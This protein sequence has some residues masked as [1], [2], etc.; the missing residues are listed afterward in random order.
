MI[1]LGLE[2]PVPYNGM[3][4]FDPT[5]AN[6]VLNAQNNYIQAMKEDY[7]RGREDLKEFNKN[8][9]DFFSPIQKD[10]EWYDQNVTGATRDFI[11]GLYERGIDP[12]RSPEARAMISR[13]VNNM[14]TGKINQL[15]QSAA[16]ANEYLKNMGKLMAEDRY[17]PDA[18]KSF[19]RDLSTW[20][21]LGG[22]GLWNTPSPVENRT[23]D[24]II[25]PIIK[26]LDYTYDEARTKQAN[27]GNDYYTVTEDRIRATIADAMEDLTRNGTMPGYYYNK[28]LQAVGG[29]KDKAI[30]LYTDW[31]TNRGKDHLKEKFTPNEFAILKKKHEYDVALENLKDKHIRDRSGGDGPGNKTNGPAYDFATD[32]YDN[33]LNNI[34]GY[35]AGHMYELGPGG[36]FVSAEQYFQGSDKLVKYQNVFGKDVAKETKDVSR[37]KRMYLDRYTHQ[38]GLSGDIVATYLG[39]DLYEKETKNKYDWKGMGVMR[40]SNDDIRRIRTVDDVVSNTAGYVGVHQKGDSELISRIK[41]NPS[42]Y[43][44]GGNNIDVYGAYNKPGRYQNDF[45][46]DVY[47]SESGKKVGT[48]GYDSYINSEKTTGGLFVGNKKFDANSSRDTKTRSSVTLGSTAVNEKLKLSRKEHMPDVGPYIAKGFDYI[49][50]EDEE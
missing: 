16:T 6:M 47:D 34:A 3:S 14:P 30:A 18:E 36:K 33:G 23:M 20:S 21:T 45:I 46:M 32:I 50:D 8:F 28:A 5:M 29:D 37:R 24:E 48:I 39:K 41:G 31:L 13:W 11:N 38:R 43:L 40:L 17:N 2:K 10:M 22:N 12:L 49:D 1:F 26:N 35:E 9:G 42:R 25:E 15:K 4:I 19:G 27:D 7:L 44:V